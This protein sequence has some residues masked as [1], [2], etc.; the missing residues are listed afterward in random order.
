MSDIILFTTPQSARNI[1]IIH[2]NLYQ[3][4]KFYNP[5]YIYFSINF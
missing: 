3:S 1:L 5:L 2:I 4:N